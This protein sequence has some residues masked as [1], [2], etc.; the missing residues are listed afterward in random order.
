MKVM[1][2]EYINRLKLSRDIF[3]D[4]E[5][6]SHLF[7]TLCKNHGKLDGYVHDIGLNPFGYCLIS[8]LQVIK[9]IL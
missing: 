9:I 1:A 8:N 2:H 7:Q 5:A 4:I 6:T 3:V